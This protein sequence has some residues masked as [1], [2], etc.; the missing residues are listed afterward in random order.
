MG[1]AALLLMVFAVLGGGLV[2]FSFHNTAE[3]IKENERA[4][5]LRILNA[6][7]PHE[8]YDNDLFHDVIKIPNDAMLGT[9]EPVTIYRARQSRQPVAAV[10]TTIVPDGYNGRINLLVGINYEGILIGVRVVSHRETPGLGDKIELRRSDWI[11]GFNGRSLTNP[12]ATN[13]KVKQDGGIFDQ[14][15]GATITPRAIVKAVYKTLLFF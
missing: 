13:W 12:N 15:T 5:L 6:L 9:T 11:L 8:Q 4:A 7:I 2:A 3:Q 1:Q 10:I 14:F